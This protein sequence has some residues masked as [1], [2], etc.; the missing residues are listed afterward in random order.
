MKELVEFSAFNNFLSGRIPSSIGSLPGLKI[1][2]LSS[3]DLFGRIPQSIGGLNNLETLGL[4]EN[5][6]FGDI[7]E[8]IGELSALRELVLSNNELSGAI[9]ESVGQ[10]T[11]LEVLQLQHNAFDSF[12]NLGKLNA[13]SLLVFDYD[14]EKADIDYRNLNFS[15]T[16]MAD[17]KFE[18]DDN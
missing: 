9:P 11:N 17:T 7:P 14:V 13:R 16:R 8:S 5:Q 12:E 10:L 18:D 2:N 3:N 4:F 1:L 15:R 6:L